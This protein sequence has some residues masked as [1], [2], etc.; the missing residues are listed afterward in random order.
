MEYSSVFWERCNELQDIERIM[1]QVERGEA[2]IQRRVSIKRALDAKVT[3][4]MTIIQGL[5]AGIKG[6]KSD[7]L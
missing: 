5:Y 3:I 1:A 2:K 4:I 7:N 6:H